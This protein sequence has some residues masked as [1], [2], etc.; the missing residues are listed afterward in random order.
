MVT[1]GSIY[2]SGLSQANVCYNII[3]EN[4]RSFEECQKGA[5]CRQSAV[6]KCGRIQIHKNTVRE[7]E[8]I[9]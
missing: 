1:D 4:I 3:S 5:S 7:K 6:R 2:L 8:T 9:I